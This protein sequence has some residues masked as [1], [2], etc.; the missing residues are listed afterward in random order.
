MTRTVAVVPHTH[1]DRE[2]YLPFQAFRLR[3]V[4]LLDDLLPHL[5]A[6]PGYAHFLLDGQL[7]VVDDYVAV[8]PAAEQAIA[9]ARGR[10]PAL[11]RAVVHVAGRVP[12]VRAR[13]SSAT[14]SSASSARRRLGG[15]M[16]RRLPAR[17]VRA[18]GP[19]A[20]AAPAVRHR[21]RRGVAGR[22]GGGR[23][24]RLS[25]GR[26]RRQR[27]AG[28]VPAGGLRQRRPGAARRA[29]ASSSGSTSSPTA[30]TT[31]LAGG[32]VLW[33]NGTDHLLP[34]PWLAEVVA[35]A[36]AV[37]S[38]LGARGRVAGALPRRD[39]VTPRRRRRRSGRASSGR[40]RGRTSSWAWR[41]TGSTCAMPRRAPSAR[42]SASPSRRARCSS[43]R[44]RGRRHCSTRPGSAS[45]GTRPT[46]RC[47]R[48]PTTRSSTPSSFAT[49]RRA[50]SARVSPIGRSAAVGAGGRRRRSGRRQPVGPH[51]ERAGRARAPRRGRTARR[52]GARTPVP[53]NVALGEFASASMAAGIVAE[54]EY[55]PR[56]LSA[57]I[58]DAATGD[59][60]FAAT[61]AAGGLLVTPAARQVLEALM[62]RGRCAAAAASGRR[63]PGAGPQGAGA[64]RRR[65]RLRV[66]G[67]GRS[68]ERGERRR[69]RR[70]RSGRRRCDRQ[71][72]R[73]RRRVRLPLRRRWR[74]RRHVQLVPAGRAT[75]R[76]SSS[77]STPS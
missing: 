30:T 66:G 11:A 32:P 64:R 29:M 6:D 61:R 76:P 4:E 33:M 5:E 10:R 13:R 41:R 26:P 60:R 22:P 52:P 55:V 72:P 17:H 14:C 46:T 2:W 42:S 37:Q 21:R 57:R 47:A 69:G 45:S 31:M 65:A 43:R 9:P 24:H 35:K 18:R 74:R 28:R 40:A 34:Q 54:L 23:A 1:W 27:R 20:P 63:H 77:S 56:Y 48:A 19:D 62:A 44:R 3:L 8:R 12:R 15:A 67:M 50:R 38:R 70:R 58:V 51:E 16:R 75:S 53:R 7:A 59:E 25:L 39:R 49:A 36:N 71:R 68:G 73:H